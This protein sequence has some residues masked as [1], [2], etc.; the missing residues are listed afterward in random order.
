M[1]PSTCGTYFSIT[2]PEECDSPDQPELHHISLSVY[3]HTE[4]DVDGRGLSSGK[5]KRLS[6]LH[7]GQTDSGTHPAS[8]PIGIRGS[9]LRGEAVGA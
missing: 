6:L 8:Y 5:G 2:S 1:S 4:T 9:F 7:S 3:T